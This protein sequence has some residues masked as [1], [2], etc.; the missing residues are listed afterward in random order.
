MSEG[1]PTK[2]IFVIVYT[3]PL[4]HDLERPINGLRFHIRDWTVI[5]GWAGAKREWVMQS[6]MRIDINLF[7]IAFKKIEK[8]CMA[9]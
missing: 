7:K 3:V 2:L 9:F 6:L 8:S 1:I 4:F 5:I